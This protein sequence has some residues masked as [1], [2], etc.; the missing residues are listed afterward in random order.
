MSIAVSSRRRADRTCA[1]SG[2]TTAAAARRSA[3]GRV[4][5]AA[6]RRSRWHL[7]VPNTPQLGPEP[8]QLLAKRVGPRAVEQRL[9]RPEVAAQPARGD[10]SLV[11]VLD[12]EPEADPRVVAKQAD[13]R[14]GERAADHVTGGGRRTERPAA[15][16]RAAVSPRGRARGR[17]ARAGRPAA[18]PR[19]RTARRSGR[20][21]DLARALDRS[22]SRNRC[23]IRAPG[24]HRHG[25]VDET[26]E[27]RRPLRRAA[28]CRP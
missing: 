28:P 21:S 25:R 26:R 12:V 11:D 14:R 10:A 5:A 23:V 8:A 13:D 27:P 2:A 22:I 24:V 19:P 9:E 15:R 16:A 7:G 4:V 3:A 20:S 6:R 17:R 1:T 18:H